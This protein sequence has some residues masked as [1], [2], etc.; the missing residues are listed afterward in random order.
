MVLDG[1]GPVW[2]GTGSYLVVLGHYGAVLVDI[3]WYMVSTR[4]H[5]LVVGGAGS[6]W[7]G[8][9]WYLVVLG[10]YKLVSLVSSRTGLQQGLFVLK[11][12]EIWL[13]VTIA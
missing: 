2:S 6:V 7:C 4:Q 5:W 10:Q 1:T 11:K 8:T 3:R 12:V 9:G 13:D